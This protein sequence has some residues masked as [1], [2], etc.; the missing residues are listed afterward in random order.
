MM[1]IFVFRGYLVR[2]LGFLGVFLVGFFESFVGVCVGSFFN[3]VSGEVLCGI[4][5][6][7]YVFCFFWFH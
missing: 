4:F 3:F 2:L 6:R 7:V 5:W 1:C